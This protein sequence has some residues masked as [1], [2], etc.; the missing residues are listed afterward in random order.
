MLISIFFCGIIQA[1]S[2]GKGLL[3]DAPAGDLGH[4]GTLLGL[5]QGKGGSCWSV[6]LDLN[7]AALRHSWV[8]KNSF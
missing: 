5:L 2:N 6:N 4:L 8:L 7:S 1:Y 3:A